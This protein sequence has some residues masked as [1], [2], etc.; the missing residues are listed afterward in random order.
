MQK[1]YIKEVFND[2]KETNNLIE[3]QIEKINL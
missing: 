3:A 2:Y 1:K